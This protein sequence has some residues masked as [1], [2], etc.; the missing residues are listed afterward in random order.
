MKQTVLLIDDSKFLRK[1]NELALTRS[2]YNVLGAADGEEGL[3]LACD[4]VPDVIVLDMMLPKISGP[5]LL[6]S[7]K[8][9]PRTARIP[10]IVVSSL[11]QKNEEKLI[12]EGAAAYFEKSSLGLES[13]S[14]RL[15]DAISSVLQTAHA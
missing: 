9:D 2:G 10:V 3:R 14:S 13:G 15:V 4:R 6:Q 12:N 8:K 7:L 11:S 1:A 5:Q